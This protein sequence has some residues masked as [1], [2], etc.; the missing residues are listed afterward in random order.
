MKS[1][2]C[3]EMAK[4]IFVCHLGMS[5]GEAEKQLAMIFQHGN[6]TSVTHSSREK[7]LTNYSENKKV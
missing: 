5:E 2:C 3:Y 7:K 1:D 6:S 4:D